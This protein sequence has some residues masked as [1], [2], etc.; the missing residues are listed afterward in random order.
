MMGDTVTLQ[1]S[2]FNGSVPASVRIRMGRTDPYKLDDME[3]TL[4]WGA[5]FLV[6]SCSTYFL[7]SK[8]FQ[9]KIDYAG[10]VALVTG[11]ASGI[12]LELCK[13]LLE[14]HITVV[15]WDVD[16]EALCQAVSEVVEPSNFLYVASKTFSLSTVV[17]HRP[18]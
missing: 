7:Y 16:E 10:S 6:L 3:T 11:G 13:Q 4:S 14:H 15:I 18:R 12:G 17:R 8:I 9:R 2:R 5:L 1:L